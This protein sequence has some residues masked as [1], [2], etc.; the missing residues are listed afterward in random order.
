ME[1]VDTLSRFDCLLTPDFSLYLEMP[2]VMQMWNVYRSRLI[3]R[4]WQNMGLVVIPTVSWADERSFAFCFD[5]LPRKSTV[6]IST[7]GVKKDTKIFKNGLDEMIE[8][9][10]PSRI[11]LYG[12][13][14]DYNFKNIE[15]IEYKNKVTERMGKK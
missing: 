12:G 6:S 3:G 1:Y 5:G 9:I 15:V 11:L 7:I 13:I 4:Q 14:I 8:R 2:L 10:N